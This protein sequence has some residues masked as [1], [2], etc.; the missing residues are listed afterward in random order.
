MKRVVIAGG[1]GYLGR[2]L[3]RCLIERGDAVCILTRQ[4]EVSRRAGDRWCELR[5]DGRNTGD[6]VTALEGADVLINLT[7]K[8]V[9]SRPTRANRNEIMASRVDSVRVLGQAL[10]MIVNPP[11]VWVQ[12]GSLAIY[13]D[14]GDRVCDESAHV[15]EAWPANVCTA[16]E[17]A[18]GEALLANTRWVTLRIGFVIGRGGGALPFLEKLARWGPGGRIGSGRQWISWAH[19]V[20]IDRVFLRAIDEPAMCGVYHAT[21]PE[22]VTNSE[23]MRTLRAVLKRPWSPPVPAPAVYLGAWLVGSDPVI[24]LTGRRCVPGRLSSE[25]FEFNHP[26][27]DGALRDLYEKRNDEKEAET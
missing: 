1:S 11:E 2:R 14:A 7:G 18:L 9:N 3:A 12:A 10:R 20:D 15:T 27:L 25:G 5:W 21:G 24:A 17:E 19:E 26:R 16:W 23:L 4:P 22:P 6:W 13:G 8:N